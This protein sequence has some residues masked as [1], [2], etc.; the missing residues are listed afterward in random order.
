MKRLFSR[1]HNSKRDRPKEIGWVSLLI[2]G[3]VVAIIGGFVGG[4]LVPHINSCLSGEKEIRSIISQSI[5]L[6]N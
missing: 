1:S 3:I 2:V 5:L 6:L 4:L